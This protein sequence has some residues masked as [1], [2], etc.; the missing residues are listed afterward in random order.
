MC[1][2][3]DPKS[4]VVTDDDSDGAPETHAAAPAAKRG[5]WDLPMPRFNAA[6]KPY[7]L[8]KRLN[9]L[10]EDL[11]GVQLS[12]L[13]LLELPIFAYLAYAYRAEF[14]TWMLKPMFALYLFRECFGMSLSLHRYFS[15]KGFQCGRAAQFVLWW[16]G[17]MASQGPPL[18][19]AS[20]HRRHHAKCDT[21]EDPHTPVC[22]N[23]LYAWVGWTYLPGA[24]GPFGRGIDEEYV[25]DHM[26]FPELV[27]GET[28]HMVPV[29]VT[30]AICY[31]LGGAPYAIYISM[32]SGMVCQ[33]ATMY[34]NVAFH[35]PEDGGTHE[36][37]GECHARDIPLDPLAN[38]FG[39]AYHAWHHIHP[40]AHWRP[41]IDLPY[42]LGI[43]PMLKLG[44]FRGPNIMHKAKL[45]VHGFDPK[46]GEKIDPK[47]TY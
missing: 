16:L 28:F 35:T 7:P 13:Y 4:A 6:H 34:F 8:D 22:F 11:P 40:R 31:K 27:Y 3:P 9:L 42:F 46:T 44:V 21:E 26:K 41:G 39:E 43:W 17:C 12:P 33:L 30:H 20:K 23:P 47:K 24:E 18:W 10:F 36:A 32:L 1:L 25:G 5:R 15:H 14:R 37:N 2:P 45:A 19:W 38:V 29:F